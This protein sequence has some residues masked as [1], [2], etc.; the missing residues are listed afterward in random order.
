MLSVR[1]IAETERFFVDALGFRKTGQEGA[2]HRFEIGEG[3]AAKR[4][5][6]ELWT[7]G[8]E[9]DYLRATISES[10]SPISTKEPDPPLLSAA[11]SCL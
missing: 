10:L 11:S 5:S 1:E 7:A 9:D 4:M 2:Y 6:L 3:G 8:E